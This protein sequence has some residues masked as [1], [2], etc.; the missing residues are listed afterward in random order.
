MGLMAFFGKLF[1]KESGNLPYKN[2]NGNGKTKGNG[3]GTMMMCVECKKQFLFETGEQQ[4]FKM[5]GLTPPKRCPN[6]RTK[7]RRHRR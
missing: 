1:G 3:E 2:G 6:C 7:R 5:R 4:F